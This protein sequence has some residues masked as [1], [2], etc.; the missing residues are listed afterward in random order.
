MGFFSRNQTTGDAI[1]MAPQENVEYKVSAQHLEGARPTANATPGIDPELERRVLR[2]IDLRV[3][4]LL[5]FFYLLAF[6]DRSNIGYFSRVSKTGVY[7][8]Y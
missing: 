3:P 2:K 6:L 5:S 1:Q 7:M 8:W 4:T